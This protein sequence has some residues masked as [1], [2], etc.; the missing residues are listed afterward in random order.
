MLCKALSSSSILFIAD[1]FHPVH[2]PT[3]DLFQKQLRLQEAR[4]LMLGQNLDATS[5]AYR[6]GYDDASHFNREYKRLFGAPPMRDVERL[7]EAVSETAS[8][9]QSPQD[10]RHLAR[11]H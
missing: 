6:V 11:I 5:A 1:L 3:V 9:I 4:R 7:R 2:S 10:T 8:S